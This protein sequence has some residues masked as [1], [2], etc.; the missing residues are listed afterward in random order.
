[1]IGK[2]R[3]NEDRGA[4]SSYHSV[5]TSFCHLFGDFLSH[6]TPTKTTEWRF[7]APIWKRVSARTDFNTRRTT[8]QEIPFAI[9]KYN[10]TLSHIKRRLSAQL[11]HPI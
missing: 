10:D 2:R 5:K 9:S 3:H 7:F 6:W 4:P 8:I 1:M 11:L